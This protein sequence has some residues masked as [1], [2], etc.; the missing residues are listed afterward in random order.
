MCSWHTPTSPAPTH[1][2]S[3]LGHCSALKRLGS[4]HTGDSLDSFVLK[5]PK[6]R[7]V[8]ASGDRWGGV[9]AVLLSLITDGSRPRRRPLATFYIA[10]QCMMSSSQ[11][12][13]C[14]T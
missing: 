8:R 1:A 11:A 2:L 10:E 12:S 7:P 6:N 9:H 4:K 14:P 3:Q 5:V 13:K